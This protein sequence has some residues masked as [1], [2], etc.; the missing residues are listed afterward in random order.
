M[1]LD[2]KKVPAKYLRDAL[3][4]HTATLK[5]GSEKGWLKLYDQ[6]V[7]RDPYADIAIEKSE[8]LPLQA[9]QEAAFNTVKE[10]MDNQEDRVFLLQ[11][12][13]G[14]GKTEVYLQLIQEALDKDKGLFC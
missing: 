14:S 8:K 1:E 12:V 13:T 6:Q 4:L 3:D 7:N 9:Q 11:G 2:G 5:A 10:A